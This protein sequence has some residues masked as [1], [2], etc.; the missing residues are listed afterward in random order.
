M[1]ATRCAMPQSVCRLNLEEYF[2]NQQFTMSSKPRW[3]DGRGGDSPH[4]PTDVDAYI[5]PTESERYP[6]KYIT[7][8]MSQYISCCIHCVY[9]RRLIVFLH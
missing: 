1:S 8:M 5:K 3:F 6:Y 2:M 7:N 9:H 4:N